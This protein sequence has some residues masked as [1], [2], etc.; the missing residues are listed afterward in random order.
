MTETALPRLSDFVAAQMGLHFPPERWRDLERG[1]GSAARE[2][3]FADTEAFA[4]WLLTSPLT[5]NRVEVLASH[6]TV[7][8][9]YFF[10]DKRT[11]ELLEEQILPELIRS[12]RA[13]AQRLRIW[14]AG[15][16]T[17]EEPYSI[18]ILLHKL[19][20]DL[21]RW[22]IALLATDI[23]PRFLQKASAGEYGEWSFRE[24]QNWLKERYF[25]K[26][27]G[28]RF[29]IAPFI[30]KL[31][32]FSHLNLAED[33]YPALS[34]DTN[35]MDLIFCRNV[36]MYFVPERQKK[37]VDGF[38]R[39]LVEG[40]WLIVSPSEASHVLFSTFMTVNFPS[41][42][43]YRKA[44]DKAISTT[45]LPSGVRE[46]LTPR[47]HPPTFY[48]EPPEQVPLIPEFSESP[49]FMAE[50][51]PKKEVRPSLYQEALSLYQL[52]RYGDAAET[53]TLWLSENP[54]DS[55]AMNMMA[56][57]YANQG[58]LTQALEWCEKAL[59]ADK[60]N[61]GCHYLR[62]M[63]LQEDAATE[64]ATVSLKR[65]LYLDPQFVMAHYSLGNLALRQG[66][67]KEAEKHLDN[68]LSLLRL[69]RPEDIVP[70]S[71]GI[72]A[73]RLMEII[74]STCCRY[75]FV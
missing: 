7:G 35:A 47:F 31:V 58:Q 40:G 69:Y 11:F 3:G 67:A 56:R 54:K 68:A 61:T 36:L 45:D 72:T 19:I 75:T 29:R 16:A 34:N 66:K 5:R 65:T 1:I 8:E 32:S 64:E 70:E 49:T 22:N 60:L 21:E 28:G 12:R 59:A 4:Q 37:V 51:D 46:D 9:T 55:N 38:H 53:I 25:K 42:I 23:N 14:S 74:A 41:A 17:G 13:T 44:G 30:Q 71:E 20:P 43:L 2:F 57:L 62:A 52:G 50:V 26:T 33:V 18:A 15:C 39:T 63:I 73:G 48:P 24:T 27:E 6:L 10:R